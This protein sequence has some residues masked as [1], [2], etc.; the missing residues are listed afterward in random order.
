MGFQ[1]MGHMTDAALREEFTALVDKC[2]NPDWNGYGAEPI[3]KETVSHA[4]RFMLLINPVDVLHLAP[5][6]FGGISF[7]WCENNEILVVSVEPS[8]QLAWCNGKFSEYTKSFERLPE[9]LVKLMKPG[10]IRT[11]VKTVTGRLQDVPSGSALFGS[12]EWRL[13]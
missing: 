4:E 8:G 7:N 9:K 2:S 11:N 6:L 12:P 1:E 13:V 5:E 3:L 10:W